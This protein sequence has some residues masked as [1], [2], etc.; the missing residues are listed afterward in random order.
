MA[1]VSVFVD[2]AVRGRLP[3]VCAR[4]GEPA[5]LM[6]RMHQPVGSGGLRSWAW[7]LVFLGPPGWLALLVVLLLAPPGEYLTVR[8]PQTRA[9]WHRARMLGRWR[10]GAFVL[11]AACLAA[12]FFYAG[13][14]P[15]LWVALGL[16]GF[17]IGAVLSVM[18]YAQTIG[19]ALDASRRW[20][21]LSGVHPAFVAAVEE[22]ELATTDGGR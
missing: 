12:A 11:G 18:L 13:M 5:D 9:S 6:V 3:M 2:E 10:I 8:V 21:T 16:A 4:T 15:L 7:L 1:A 19:V 14:F 17:V 22:R 20:V